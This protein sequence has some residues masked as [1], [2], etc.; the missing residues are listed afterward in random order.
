MKIL[1]SKNSEKCGQR[2]VPES[3]AVFF[4][5]PKKL[6]ILETHQIFNKSINAIGP[7]SHNLSKVGDG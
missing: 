6:A 3:V 4:L 2:L 7:K 5:P 1:Q